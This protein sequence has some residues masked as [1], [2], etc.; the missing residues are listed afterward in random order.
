ML[1]HVSTVCVSVTLFTSTRKSTVNRCIL[2]DCNILVADVLAN[3]EVLAEDFIIS[4]V[5]VTSSLTSGK[6]PVCDI[7]GYDIHS[8]ILLIH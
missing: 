1:L 6:C 8:A 4:D 5:Q 2:I 7:S 3:D